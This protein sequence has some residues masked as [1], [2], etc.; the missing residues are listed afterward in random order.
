MF[1]DDEIRD[2]GTGSITRKEPQ[3]RAEEFLR[4]IKSWAD[5]FPRLSQ[6]ADDR[7]E[8]I[9]GERANGG[10]ESEQLLMPPGIPKL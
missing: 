1:T 7:R 3:T 4:W 9:Y 6:P 10:A 2:S 5:R 8:S